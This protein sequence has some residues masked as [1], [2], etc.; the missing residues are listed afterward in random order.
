M[1][2]NPK[3]V[4]VED[5]AWVAEYLV[6]RVNRADYKLKMHDPQK[7]NLG[8]VNNPKSEVY[9]LAA[10]A[11]DLQ[12]QPTYGQEKSWLDALNGLLSGINQWIDTYMTPEDRT[13]LRTAYRVAKHKGLD[14]F[15][16]ILAETHQQVL[17]DLQQSLDLQ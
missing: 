10:T 13:R 17:A 1:A 3:K 4:T 8:N 5:A 6:S 16:L 7:R 14:A 12:R 2:R 15:D 9:R 11:I